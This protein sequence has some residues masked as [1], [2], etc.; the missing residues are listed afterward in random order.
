MPGTFTIPFI[1]SDITAKTSP[2]KKIAIDSGIPESPSF[3]LFFY[4]N[5]LQVFALHIFFVSNILS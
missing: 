4:L 1:S 5:M 2:I 3:L